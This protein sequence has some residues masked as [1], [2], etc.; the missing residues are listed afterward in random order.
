MTASPDHVLAQIGQSLGRPISARFATSSQLPS[1]AKTLKAPAQTDH[2]RS[3]STFITKQTQNIQ[4]RY[5][6]S[7]LAMQACIEYRVLPVQIVGHR[8]EKIDQLQPFTIIKTGNNREFAL[9]NSP[10][11]RTDRRLSGILKRMPNV[12]RRLTTQPSPIVLG[13]GSYG[14]VRVAKDLRSGELVAVKK[15]APREGGR[16]ELAALKLLAK[17]PEPAQALFVGMLDYAVVPG[18]DKQP[19]CYI[20]TKLMQDG[21]LCGASSLLT[22]TTGGRHKHKISLAKQIL[23]PIAELHKGSLYHCDLKPGNFLKSKDAEPQVKIGDFGLMTKHNF[24]RELPGTPCF[25]APDSLTGRALPAANDSYALGAMLFG[26]AMNAHPSAFWSDNSLTLS[27]T[28]TESVSTFAHSRPHDA[29]NAQ[30][31]SSNQNSLFSIA[32]ELMHPEPSAR[33]TPAQ[34]LAAVEAL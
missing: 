13:E 25:M 4:H 31:A 18:K 15:M 20:F 21:D 23:R 5:A 11:I 26:I 28:I 29:G 30:L 7:A 22:R 2:L 17:L 32:L 8:I 6:A 1:Q 12:K 34:A 19:K 33:L 27:N 9:L 24:P 14:R 3:L 16:R 10:T